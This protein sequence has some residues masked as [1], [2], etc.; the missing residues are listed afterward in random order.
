MTP[1]RCD[2]SANGSILTSRLI[3]QSASTPIAA[4]L[5]LPFS[6]EHLT[7]PPRP[8]PGK[9]TRAGGASRASPGRADVARLPTSPPPPDRRGGATGTAGP[10]V[11]APRT[12]GRPG[13]AN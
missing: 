10:D 11:T 12:A 13:G 1:G 4:S 5:L 9:G 8:P 3:S 6:P 2:P 7:V